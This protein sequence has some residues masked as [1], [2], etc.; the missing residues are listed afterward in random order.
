[1]RAR[2]AALPSSISS[3]CRRPRSGAN[4]R[5]FE[6]VEAA[7]A[8]YHAAA[9]WARRAAEAGAPDAQAMLAYILSSGPEEL[10]DSDAAFEWYRKS[11]EQDCPQGRLGYAIALMLRADTAEKTFAA[12]DELCRAAEA[13]LPTRITC[14]AWAPSAGSARRWMRQRRGGT[15]RSRPRPGSATRRR[16]SACCCSKAAADRLDPLNGESWLRRAA[17]GGNCEAAALLGDLYAR[18]GAL[19][20]NYVEAAHWFRTAA[21]RGH[22]TAARA[23]GMLYLTGAGVARDPDEAAAWFRRAA[24]AG[25]PR[26]QADLAALLQTGAV[27]ALAHDPPPVHEWFERAAEQG[28]LI[29]AF[30]YAVCL[31]EGVGVPRDD[32]RAAFWLKRAAE[33]VVNAQYWYGRMLAAGPRRSAGRCRGR[34]L[35]S[36]APPR[37]AWPK[38][39]LRLPNSM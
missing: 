33:G 21:E 39:R 38:R 9:L 11:A 34:R 22:K 25:D 17:L 36:L 20:P 3:A 4:A 2:S 30:N 1:M 10:R 8:D 35:G 26:A 32:E 24:E 31:A 23:L 12:R 19:P 15:T 14:S 28:D 7:G 13:G 16:G 29:G 18:G 27:S 37:P 6:P 5:L